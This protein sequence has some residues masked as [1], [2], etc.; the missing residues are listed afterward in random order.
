MDVFTHGEPLL[1]FTTQP[2]KTSPRNP[3][4]EWVKETSL[5]R[6]PET[7]IFS[8]RT[9]CVSKYCPRPNRRQL[10]LLFLPSVMWIMPQ[11][12]GQLEI[13]VRA[14]TGQQ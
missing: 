6:L 3:D 13:R 8:E 12:F 10:A 2:H 14:S 1:K 9:P 4:D 11:L 7:S 5:R